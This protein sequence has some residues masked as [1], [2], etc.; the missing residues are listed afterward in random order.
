MSAS[1]TNTEN[2][3]K[4]P[5]PDL[6]AL[7]ARLTALHFEV[8]HPRVF[9]SNVIYDTPDADL[10]RRGELIRLRH[11]GGLSTFTYKGP[12][13]ITRHKEREELEVPIPDPETFDTILNRLG[14]VPRFRYEKFR[15]EWARPGEPGILMVDETPIGCFLELEGPAPWIDRVADSLGYSLA[16]YLHLSYARLYVRECEQR[17]VPPADMVF[18]APVESRT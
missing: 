9:E 4:V 17:G 5:V 1:G 8:L 15:T 10:R 12:A 2:E 3:V 7:N 13:R 14:Y 6:P 16:D 11:A 18:P